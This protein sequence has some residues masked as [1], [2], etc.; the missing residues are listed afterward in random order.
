MTKV[1]N[2]RNAPP[3]WKNNK[4]YVYIG[5]GSIFGNPFK[6]G[7]VCDLC[8]QLHRNGGSTLDCFRNYF[9]VK[10]TPQ[11]AEY[12][13]AFTKQCLALY[14]KILVCFCKPLPCHGDIISRWVDITV[15][16][17]LDRLD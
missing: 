1:I 17:C 6:I 9:E 13:E 8:G 3:G 14:G 16:E 10:V 12:D 5:R 11:C 4:K 7:V 15:A 2:I